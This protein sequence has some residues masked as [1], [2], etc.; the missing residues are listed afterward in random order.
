MPTSERW[1]TSTWSRRQ[2][3]GIEIVAA[4][5]APFT[6]PALTETA[7]LA[8]DGIFSAAEGDPVRWL[9]VAMAPRRSRVTVATLSWMSVS[10]GRDSI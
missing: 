10:G 7:E 6:F 9:V 8:P 4:G 1:R 3:T 5:P 2:G